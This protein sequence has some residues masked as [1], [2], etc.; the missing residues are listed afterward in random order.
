[1]NKKKGLTLIIGI[2]C[3]LLVLLAAA[4]AIVLDLQSA[5]PILDVFQ[6]EPTG[7]TQ[8]TDN[9][10]K[11]TDETSPSSPSDEQSTPPQDLPSSVVIPSEKDPQTGEDLGISFPCQIPGY[12]L[13]IEKMAPYSGMFVEDGSNTD[14]ENVAMLLVTNN[15][16]F[17]VEYTQIRVMCGQEE[18]LFSISALPVGE[19]LVVQ[20]TSGKPL[21]EG[22]AA[23]ASALIVQRANMELSESEVKVTDNGN[24]TLT[25]Q[26]LTDKT[27]P[28]VRVFYKY[29]MEDEK[30]FVG[31]IAFTVRISRLD[32][33]AST[34]VQP[35]HY[36]SK[37]CRVVMVLTY[38][39][40]V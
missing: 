37:N 16:D 26:N 36:T 29:Y 3:V 38:D 28:T 40:E 14:T 21:T 30:L 23:S 10:Q 33:G 39:S 17:P 18:L 6:T 13:T 32:A 15:G 8:P 9:T 22:K 25:I 5:D 20:E 27:I 24:N 34:T 7:E 12:N 11:P 1:M 4:V 19:K 35:S 2:V 31:G